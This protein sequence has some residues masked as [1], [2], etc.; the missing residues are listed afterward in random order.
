[1]LFTE[2]GKII[3]TRIMYSGLGKGSTFTFHGHYASSVSSNDKVCCV[4]P[5]FGSTTTLARLA[6][7][8]KIVQQHQFQFL[9]IQ[10]SACFK[11]CAAHFFKCDTQAFPRIT[12]SQ[13]HASYRPRS[14]ASR[15]LAFTSRPSG[16]VR[17]NN[18]SWRRVLLFRNMQHLPPSLGGQNEVSKARLGPVSTHF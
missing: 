15:L 8:A 1:M 17:T 7:Q 12:R 18:T 9:G 16:F 14:T 11:C 10:L 3:S 6:H 2:P 13:L 4:V 5:G